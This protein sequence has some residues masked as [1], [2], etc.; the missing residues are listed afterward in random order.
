[1]VEAP[2]KSLVLAFFKENSVAFHTL[3]V[4]ST[5]V[6]NSTV[7]AVLEKV[8]PFGIAV[9]WFVHGAVPRHTWFHN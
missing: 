3:E 4:G 7:V 6:A 2:G 1:M 5:L 9:C 8:F